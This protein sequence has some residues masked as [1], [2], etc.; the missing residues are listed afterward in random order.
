MFC[1]HDNVTKEQLPSPYLTDRLSHK[2]TVEGA[3]NIVPTLN[4]KTLRWQTSSALQHPAS[5]RP[6]PRQLENILPFSHTFAA[7]AS[8]GIVPRTSRTK[9]PRRTSQPAA[10]TVRPSRPVVF[11]H[12]STV[13]W[14]ATGR[15]HPVR[16]D[17][18]LNE[19]SMQPTVL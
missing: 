15:M 12:S 11:N 9:S 3:V 2:G 10:A 4:T 19:D 17:L 5:T 18:R 16:T 8:I 14:K 7:T 13:K 6:T 1:A